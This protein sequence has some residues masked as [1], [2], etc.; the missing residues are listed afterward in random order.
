MYQCANLAAK[1]VERAE[2]HGLKGKKR[3]D[4]AIAYF[5]GAAQVTEFTGPLSLHEELLRVLT[6]K[7]CT[8]GYKAVQEIANTLTK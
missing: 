7:I 6:L 2:F 1:F 4:E 8:R 3:D 5:C